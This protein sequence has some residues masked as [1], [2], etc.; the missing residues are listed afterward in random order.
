VANPIERDAQIKRALGFPAETF[1]RLAGLL[2]RGV[3]TGSGHDGTLR[4]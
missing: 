1:T 4:A 2:R 3:A